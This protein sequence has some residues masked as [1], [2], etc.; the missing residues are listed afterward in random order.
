MRD[1]LCVLGGIAIGAGLCYFGLY[2]Y[3]VRSFKDW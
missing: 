3:L 2:A 1:V